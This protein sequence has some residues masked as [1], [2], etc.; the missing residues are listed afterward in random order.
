MINTKDDPS[1]IGAPIPDYESSD[2]DYFAESTHTYSEGDFF[3]YVDTAAP[4]TPFQ[5]ESPNIYPEGSAVKP[6]PSPE[7]ENTHPKVNNS[8]NPVWT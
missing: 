6:N 7:V 5:L 2:D 1:P 8:H 3:K 4:P